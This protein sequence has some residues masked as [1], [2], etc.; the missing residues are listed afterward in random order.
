MIDRLESNFQTAFKAQQLAR[1]PQLSLFMFFICLY[2]PWETRKVR[3]LWMRRE[4]EQKKFFLQV[5]LV[6]RVEEKWKKNT[7]RLLHVERTRKKK[8][9]HNIKFKIFNLSFS[10][11]LCHKSNK[12]ELHQKVSVDIERKNLWKLFFLSIDSNRYENSIAIYAC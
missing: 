7:W 3:L 6:D 8:N 5:I 9:L 12:A 2:I 1:L 11:F 4:K 10:I